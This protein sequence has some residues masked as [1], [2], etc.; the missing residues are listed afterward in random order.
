MGL[1]P[2]ADLA[3][4]YRVVIRRVLLAVPPLPTRC[5]ITGR[6][7]QPFGRWKVLNG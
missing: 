5:P 7:N 4:P 3:D 6:T 2:D 1:D